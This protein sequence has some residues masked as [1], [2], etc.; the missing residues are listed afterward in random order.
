MANNRGMNM[1][2]WRPAER[3][4]RVEHVDPLIERERQEAEDR[5]NRLRH[6]WLLRELESLPALDAFLIRRV[7]VDGADI[8]EV[9]RARRIERRAL[10]RRLTSTVRKLKEAG[11]KIRHQWLEAELHRLPALDAYLVK[12]VYLDGTPEEDLAATWGIGPAELSRRL[13][14]AMRKLKEAGQ[15]RECQLTSCE[16]ETDGKLDH[17]T[18]CALVA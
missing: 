7:Y 3:L 4:P 11:R 2:G 9:A 15:I 17:R 1:L 16:T 6:E 12:R 10:L 13:S 8:D 14:V 5:Y 18:E